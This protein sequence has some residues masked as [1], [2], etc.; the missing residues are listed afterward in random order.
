MAKTEE[1]KKRTDYQDTT[2]STDVRRRNSAV[3]VALG[4]ATFQTLTPKCRKDKKG[5]VAITVLY[6]PRYH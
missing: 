2:W 5:G 3:S 1:K 6:M 4:G